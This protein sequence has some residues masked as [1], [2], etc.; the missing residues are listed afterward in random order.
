MVCTSF[1]R[2]HAYIHG[3]RSHCDLTT[4]DVTSTG[5]AFDNFSWLTMMLWQLSSNFL[6][7]VR[8]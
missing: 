6:W 3:K 2:L 1:A 7:H 4:A 8:R 5:H